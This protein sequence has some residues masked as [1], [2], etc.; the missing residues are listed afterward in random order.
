M[1]PDSRP[2]DLKLA[3]LGY[4]KIDY[5]KKIDANGASYISKVKS[6]FSLYSKNKNPELNLNGE[7][8]KRLSI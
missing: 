1:E 4:H 8:K 7:I 2:K 5:L 3:D 6:S